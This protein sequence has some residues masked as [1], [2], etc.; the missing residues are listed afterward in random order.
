MVQRYRHQGGRSTRRMKE[1][2]GGRTPGRGDSPVR[3]RRA[4]LPGPGA[5]AADSRG[6]HP[7]DPGRGPPTPMWV[8]PAGKRRRRAAPPPPCSPCSGGGDAPARFMGGPG[9]LH[10]TIQVSTPPNR[11]R[12][13]GPPGPGTMKAAEIERRGTGAH[14]G[15][16]APRSRH[17]HPPR[18]CPGEVRVASARAPQARPDRKKEGQEE[19]GAPR[20]GPPTGGGGGGL[21]GG[22]AL[23]DVAGEPLGPIRSG[24][25][26][27]VV[28]SSLSRWDQPRTGRPR[29]PP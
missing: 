20:R 8:V 1:S 5:G 3:S 15:P 18:S 25:G 19:G 10:R 14:A 6:V 21:E 7:A 12:P 13:H 28:C 9:E 27:H 16:P 11:S 2:P 24:S 26:S 23:P 22:E 17:R 4:V 29:S